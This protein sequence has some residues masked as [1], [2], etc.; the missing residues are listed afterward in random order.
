MNVRGVLGVTALIAAFLLAGLG[1]SLAGAALWKGTLPGEGGDSVTAATPIRSIPIATAQTGGARPGAGQ[2]GNQG[3]PA[4]GATPA[5]AAAARLGALDLI[6]CDASVDCGENPNRREWDSVSACVRVQGGDNRPLVLAITTED[7]SP[8]G[9]TRTPIVGRSEEF[10]AS[11]SLTCHA[12]R[13]LRGTLRPGDYW[14][15]LVDGTTLLGQKQFHLG[16]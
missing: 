3:R 8:V 16:P 14:M 11:Q 13:V 15:W 4:T 2:G 5:P 6:V 10:R 12:V 7:T 9:A 1:I